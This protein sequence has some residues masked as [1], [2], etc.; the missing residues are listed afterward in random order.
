MLENFSLDRLSFWLG[1][2]AGVIFWFL[3]GRIN[4]RIPQYKSYLEKSRSKQ[5]KQKHN[6]SEVI[7]RQETY[8]RAQRAHLTSD[9]FPLDQ[10]I[11]KPSL[12]NPPISPNPEGLFGADAYRSQ[13]LL[14]EFVGMAEEA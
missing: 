2:T 14:T 12:C 10:I 5:K 4:R 1:F 13:V 11:I 9:I 8:R 6:A 3:I 7:W